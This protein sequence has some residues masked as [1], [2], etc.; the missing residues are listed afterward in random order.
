[1]TEAEAEELSPQAQDCH[2]L[3]ANGQNQRSRER[4]A[5]GFR[6]AGPADTLLTGSGLQNFR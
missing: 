4:S 2:G 5:Q 1:M 6:G 3:V